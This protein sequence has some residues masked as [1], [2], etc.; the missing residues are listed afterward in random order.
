[1]TGIDY[2][3]VGAVHC[4]AVAASVG[5]A[6]AVEERAG[7]GIQVYA[8]ACAGRACAHVEPRVGGAG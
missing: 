1:M 3:V 4:D 7:V 5:S 6:C 2:A 8:C